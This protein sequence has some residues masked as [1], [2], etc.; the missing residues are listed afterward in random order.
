MEFKVGDLVLVSGLSSMNSHYNGKILAIDYIH[1][2][3]SGTTV[4][5][6]KEFTGFIYRDQIKPARI[7]NTVITRKLYPHYEEDGEWL[8]LKS[9]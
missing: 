1:N 4:Y 5:N 2:L 9:M 6:F 3:Q 7:A 8:I